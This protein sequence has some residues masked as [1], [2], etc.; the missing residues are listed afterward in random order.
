M[1]DD[2]ALQLSSAA[3]SFDGTAHETGGGVFGKQRLGARVLDGRAEG[4]RLARLS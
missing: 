4:V 1:K 2:H 3:M